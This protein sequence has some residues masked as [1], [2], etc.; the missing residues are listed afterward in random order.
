MILSVAAAQR[1]MRKVSFGLCSVSRADFQVN[2]R[3]SRPINQVVDASFDAEK[4]A[5]S[6]ATAILP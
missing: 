5:N 6:H 1:D 2:I 4:S 3:M